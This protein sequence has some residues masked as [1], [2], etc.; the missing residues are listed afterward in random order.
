MTVR[1]FATPGA[2]ADAAA[3]EIASWLSVRGGDRTIGLAGGST[4][5]LAYEY[6]RDRDVPWREVHAW[7]TDER[8]VPV[9][10]P[11]SNAGMARAA[12]FDHVP[13]TLHEVPWHEDARAA[14]IEYE[15]ELA[16]LLPRR[17][18][19][20]E[21]GLVILG[22]GADGHTASLFPGSSAIAEDRRDFVA[23]RV[24]GVGWRLTATIPMLARARRTIFI[25]AG[26]AKASAVAEILG[27]D[28]DLPAALVADASRDPIWLLDTEAA[29]SL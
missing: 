4:P 26:R 8:H 2:L 23:T 28:S 24:D 6:L 1:I 29:S 18:A 14:A 22:V 27:G 15:V 11:E 5:R 7:M 17:N 16:T 19:L 12:L 9:D 25:V 13:A 20:V 21:P 3:H 10:D